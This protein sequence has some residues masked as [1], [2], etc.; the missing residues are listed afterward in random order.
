MKPQFIPN[1]TLVVFNKNHSW[2]LYFGEALCEVTS[3]MEQSYYAKDSVYHLKFDE[4]A[5]QEMRNDISM[6]EDG[7]FVCHVVYFE[8]AENPIDVSGISE[9]L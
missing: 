7:S 9:L 6:E 5:P 8:L 2:N 3:S 1:G 4:S